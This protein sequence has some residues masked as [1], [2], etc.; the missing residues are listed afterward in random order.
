V[1]A[2]TRDFKKI[3]IATVVLLVSAVFVSL[4]NRDSSTYELSNDLS[5][6]S[7][8]IATNTDNRGSQLA[9]VNLNTIFGETISTSSLIG[10]PTIINIWYST[11]EPCRRELPVLAQGALQYSEKIR[12]IGINIKDSAKVASEFASEYGV[13]FEI[14]LDANGSFISASG[15]GTAPMTLA[16]NSQGLII[17]Q[18]AGELSTA[19]LDELVSE[20]LK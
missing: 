13:K 2:R 10:A 15:I 9:K 20:L 4:I 5:N 17:N 6:S 12:F 11:C 8:G 18:I 7:N 14:F 3:Y 1:P 19:K 16:V